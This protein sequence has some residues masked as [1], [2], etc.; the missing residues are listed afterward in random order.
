M[1]EPMDHWIKEALGEQREVPADLVQRAKDLVPGKRFSVDCPH[2][3]KAITPFKK[4]PSA[5]INALWLVAALGAFALSFV[6]RR[7]FMQCLAVSVVC[8]FKWAIDARA[9]KTKILIY[10]ALQETESD[11]NRLHRHSSHL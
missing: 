1:T 6:I 8:A 11:P 9:M 10:K 2:C 4:Q 7:Y 5:W 3:G